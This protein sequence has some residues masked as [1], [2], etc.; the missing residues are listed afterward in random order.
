MFQRIQ[1]D[2][3]VPGKRYKIGET[4]GIFI[5]IC[6]RINGVWILKFR[7]LKKDPNK[8]TYL[9]HDCEFYQFIPQM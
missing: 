3:M 7:G 8:I 5:K 2:A 9:S 1:Y 4:S 6:Y